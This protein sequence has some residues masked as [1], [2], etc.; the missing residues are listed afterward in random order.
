MSLTARA[1]YFILLGVVLI[2]SGCSRRPV[3]GILL[4]T[5]GDIG[6]YGQAMKKAIDLAVEEA[7][8]DGTYPANLELVWADSKSDPKTA[9]Q[10]FRT[11]VSK[12]GAKLVIAGVTSDEIRDLLPVFEQT[13]T[14]CLSPS[15]SAPI[16]TKE[17]EFFY[18]LFASDD[19]EG[20][21]AGRFLYEDWNKKSV[22][23][24]AGDNEQTRGIEPPFR[25]IFEQALGGKVVGKVAIAD[26][27]WEKQSADLLAAHN[28]ESVYI[29][30][31]AAETLKVLRHLR[32]HGY[33]GIICVTSAFASGEVIRKEPD[34]V[35]GV[36]F[37]QPAFDVLDEQEHVQRF[38]KAYRA[39]Y[40]SDP[41]IYAAHAYDAMRLVMFVVK[42]TPVF[43]TQNIKKTLAFGLSEFPGVTGTIQF[44]EY[45]DVAHNPIMFII[46]DGQVRNYERWVKEEKERIRREIGRLLGR[47]MAAPVPTPA[48]E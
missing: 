19:L 6:T 7:K 42:Q 20:R 33:K 48:P 44:N 25:Q 2:M 8:A 26:P 1:K 24:Y 31:Y 3:V 46:K 4:A 23:I 35:E 18:R 9:E 40:K 27:D 28:P 45:G 39:K 10:E 29:I 22:L 32:Q 41:D 47:R 13:D 30:D 11:M 43:V 38:V 21:R 37:P 34:L 16:L 15:A 5:S 36:Y 17:G 12:H 14:V